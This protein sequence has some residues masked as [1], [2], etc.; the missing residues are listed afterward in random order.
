MWAG[1]GTAEG[2]PWTRAFRHDEGRADAG[3][4]ARR[5]S[6][7]SPEQIPPRRNSTRK[8]EETAAAANSAGARRRCL[9]S[10]PHCNTHQPRK[11]SGVETPGR[12][13]DFPLLGPAGSSVS[14]ASWPSGIASA[15]V[16]PALCSAGSFLLLPGLWPFESSVQV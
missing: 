11:R 3:A 16:L 9:F 6:R 12:L 7:G 1:G 8:G 4:N 14:P 13:L 2:Q 5:G 10:P 15:A